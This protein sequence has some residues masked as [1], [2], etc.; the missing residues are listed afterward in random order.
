MVSQKADIIKKYSNSTIVDYGSG[1][2]AEAVKRAVQA[3]GSVIP[4]KVGSKIELLTWTGETPGIDEQMQFVIDSL[5]DLS[6]KPR[7]SYG[8]TITNQSGVVTNLALTPTLQSNEYHET[9]WGQRLS[10]LNERILQLWEYFA[11]GSDLSYSG[12]IP[13][14]LDLSATKFRNSQLVGSEINGWYKNRI[15]WPSA[16][17]TDDPAYIQNDLA[18]LTSDPP[19][20]SLYTSLEN[21]GVEDV[22]AEVDRIQQELMDPRLH[23]ERMDSMISAT[24]AMMG[25]GPQPVGASAPAPAPAGGGMGQQAPPA[26]MDSALTAGGSPYGGASAGAKK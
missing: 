13:S 6:G 11:S 22:E 18:Q 25:G 3:D 17:R 14:G 9:I 21:R 8:Q 24:N 16:I 12:H 15:K 4:A 26:M 23:P 10:T 20:I 7:S 5:F 2:T 1:Q 19:A